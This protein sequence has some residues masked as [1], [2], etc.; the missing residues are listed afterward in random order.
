ML[1]NKI[2]GGGKQIKTLQ[3][4]PGFEGF[5]QVEK[6]HIILAM[7]VQNAYHEKN[8]KRTEAVVAQEYIDFT[9]ASKAKEYL[10]SI[11]KKQVLNKLKSAESELVKVY[12]D[13]KSD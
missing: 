11:L 4:L 3:D 6:Y 9:E 12:Q 8:S 13:S 7:I 10:A 2:I 1:V 5:G